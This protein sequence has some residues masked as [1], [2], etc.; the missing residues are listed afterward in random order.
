MSAYAPVS[1]YFQP[2]EHNTGG[3]SV[4]SQQM[5]NHQKAI[6]TIKP[7]MR[8]Q[9]FSKSNYQNGSVRD[10]QYSTS[11][12]ISLNPYTTET[13]Y[14]LKKQQ[15]RQEEFY[16]PL[17]SGMTQ[18]QW[19]N[20]NQFQ[21]VGQSLRKKQNYHVA[22]DHY[23]NLRSMYRKINQIKLKKNQPAESTAT[24]TVARKQVRSVSKPANRS[25]PNTSKQV[26]NYNSD[27]YYMMAEKQA[28]VT[29]MKPKSAEKVSR[30]KIK[31]KTKLVSDN[32]EEN[33][34]FNV[35]HIKPATNNAIK[36][37]EK[38]KIKPQKK[39]AEKKINLEDYLGKDASLM[40]TK[41]SQIEE[42]RLANE[43]KGNDREGGNAK[44]NGKALNNDVMV[45]D[46]IKREHKKMESNISTDQEFSSKNEMGLKYKDFLPMPSEK[47]SIQDSK[48]LAKGVSKIKPNHLNDI[49]EDDE[50]IAN[51]K[52]YQNP[53]NKPTN[54]NIFVQQLNS[55]NDNDNNSRLSKANNESKGD[56]SENDELAEGHEGQSINAE[57]LMAKIPYLESQSDEHLQD[58]KQQLVE[59]IFNYEIFNEE[60]FNNFFEA[61]CLKNDHLD[62]D[63]LEQILTQVKEYL[64]E[65]FQALAEE[66]EDGENDESDNDDDQ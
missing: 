56:L 63:M 8:T 29:R 44:K 6:S 14:Q 47:N 27:A 37:T 40:K 51:A 2:N 34:N 62:P 41:K 52:N 9:T 65:Q 1:K 43:K 58:F 16:V 24:V 39:S 48:V 33:A 25:R 54:P 50:D 28:T 20:I 23:F 53:L 30:P 12:Q 57:E 26:S 7:T 18:N 55:A 35:M 66:N 3:R 59:M 19:R 22:I 42:G 15:E 17:A 4:I 31:H 49:S 60:E 45:S 61:V 5:Y 11:K 38:Q 46:A 36:A 10:V 13:L 32:F 21:I 64:F